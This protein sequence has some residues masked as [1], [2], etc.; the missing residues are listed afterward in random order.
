MEGNRLRL[1]TYS[2]GETI[3]TEGDRSYECYIVR[4]GFVEVQRS[5]AKL[6]RL[7]PGDVFGEL[8]MLTGRPRTAS[9]VALEDVECEIVD[10]ASPDALLREHP[11]LAKALLMT[12]AQ[13]L[14][15]MLDMVDHLW[16]LSYSAWGAPGR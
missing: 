10:A 3:V 6:A 5:S 8:A 2:P 14:Y 4:R 13:R 1:R 16:R 9:V 12:L 15:G 11:D 7:G